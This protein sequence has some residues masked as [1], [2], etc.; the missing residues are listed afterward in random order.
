MGDA[1]V[2]VDLGA[3]DQGDKASAVAIA[4]GNVHTCVLLARFNGVKCW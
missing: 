3:D 2:A 4:L 1:L